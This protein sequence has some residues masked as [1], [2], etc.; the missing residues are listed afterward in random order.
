MNTG[1]GVVFNLKEA[2]THENAILA[3]ER[4]DVG[5]R[6]ERDHAERLQEK[7]AK[8]RRGFFA[9]AEGFTDQPGEFE[10]HPRAAEVG[11]RVADLAD[12]RVNDRRRVRK[13]RAGG[14]VVG[15]DQLDAELLGELRD[16]DRRDAAVDSDD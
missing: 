10:R 2:V 7:L 12:A 3:G 1:A 9:V 8:H 13:H 4:N 15:D 11:T 14:V 5:N 16:L 6:R